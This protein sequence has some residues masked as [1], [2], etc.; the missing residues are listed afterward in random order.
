MIRYTVIDAFL[1]S[2]ILFGHP[3]T[4][5]FIFKNSDLKEVF[6]V[7]DK[8]GNGT[9]CTT[10]LGKVLRSLGQ[11]PTEQEIRDIINK[12]DKDSKDIC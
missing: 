2:Y 8:D 6:S 5:V 12:A 9:I 7:F 11:K 10:E 3:V 1:F 4:D